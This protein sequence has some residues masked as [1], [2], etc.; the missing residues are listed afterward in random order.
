MFESENYVRVGDFRMI[1]CFD[2][3]VIFSREI[4]RGIRFALKHYYVL[5]K[6]RS[7]CGVRWRWRISHNF[8]VPVLTKLRHESL[9]KVVKR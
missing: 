7:E 3:G 5:T 2:L 8:H 4:E 6:R 9:E 1:K